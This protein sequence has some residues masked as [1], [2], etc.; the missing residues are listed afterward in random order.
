MIR[1]CASSGGLLGGIL[2]SLG[3]ALST[4]IL[5]GPH[6]RSAYS[7]LNRSSSNGDVSCMLFHSLDAQAFSWMH[8]AE[9]APWIALDAITAANPQTMDAARNV[10]PIAELNF[11]V[12]SS[13]LSALLSISPAIAALPAITHLV[14]SL[15]VSI[16]PAMLLMISLMSHRVVSIRIL[17][18]FGFQS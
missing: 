18:K 1:A 2:E 5:R 6:R 4:S 15:G 8:I 10:I 13:T 11:P 14:N 9:C 3:V 12:N 16:D 17:Q 7:T